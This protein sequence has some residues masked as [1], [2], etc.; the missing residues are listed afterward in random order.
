MDKKKQEEKIHPKI[1]RKIQIRIWE[2]R[3]QNP[4]CKDLSLTNSISFPLSV[5]QSVSLS[6]NQSVKHSINLFVCL[7]VCLP[8]CLLVCLSA[9]LYVRASVCPSVHLCMEG[10]SDVN[11]NNS[12]KFCQTRPRAIYL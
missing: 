5:C 9:C 11:P 1:P 4:H 6:A 12:E 3:G 8:A 10:K 2:F 7:S